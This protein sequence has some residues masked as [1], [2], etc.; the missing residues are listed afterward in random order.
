MKKLNHTKRKSILLITHRD[1]IAAQADRT[2]VAKKA[3]DI[4]WVEQ[5]Q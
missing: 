4:S 3:N 2:F 5:V 1:D